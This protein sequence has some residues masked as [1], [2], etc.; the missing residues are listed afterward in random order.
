MTMLLT[1]SNMVRVADLVATTAHGAL[2]QRRKYTHEPY[3]VHPRSVANRICMVFP[4]DLELQCA[5]LLHDVVEDTHITND[6]IRD[7]FGQDIADLVASVTDVSKPTD[8]NRAVRTAIDR[9]HVAKATPRGQS[10]KVAD[11]IDNCSS[12]MVHDPKFAT[13]YLKE[14]RA[15]LQVLT[16]AHPK[17]LGQAHDLLRSWKEAK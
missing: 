12:I 3:I 1:I 8:G 14:K 15:Q 4:A 17:L 11:I 13:T 7:V 6:Y 10:L 2:D 9:A 16:K 5:A